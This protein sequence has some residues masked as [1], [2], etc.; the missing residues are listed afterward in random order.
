MIRMGTG[1][2]AVAG[3]ALLVVTAGCSALG[4]GAGPVTAE[5]LQEQVAKLAEEHGATEMIGLRIG[6][7]GSTQSGVT[8]V[9]PDGLLFKSLDSGEDLLTGPIDPAPFGSLP[10]DEYPYAEAVEA[11][12]AENTEC[13]DGKDPMDALSQ[14]EPA[15]G[16]YV[17]IECENGGVGGSWLDGERMPELENAFTQ[18]SIEQIM[19]EAEAVVGDRL[20][21][22]TFSGPGGP[23]GEQGAGARFTGAEAEFFGEAC[24]PMLVRPLVPDHQTYISPTCDEPPAESDPFAISDFPATDISEAIEFGMTELG[25]P[26]TE[27]IADVHVFIEDGKRS[28]QLVGTEQSV[29]GTILL[30]E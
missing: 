24:S 14:L 23:L 1:I 13:P 16:H 6:L 28:V 10:I 8:L 30:D 3:A 7:N 22:L 20:V 9:T 5:D 19:T 18:E 25:I 17:V 2:A 11:A 12:Q 21:E 27:E 26:S 29:M 15:G 4:G